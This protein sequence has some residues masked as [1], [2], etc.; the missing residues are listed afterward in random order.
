MNVFE[1][2][3]FIWI[4]DTNIDTYGE[5][6]ASFKANSSPICRLSCDGDYTLFINGRYVASNQYG[7]FEHYKIY[8]E[9]D[10]SDYILDGENHLAI[11]VHHFGK[12]SQR[13]KR[14]QTGVIF[15]ICENNEILLASNESIL[16][17]KSKSY[18]S[19]IGRE[20][21][22]QLGFSYTYDAKNEDLWQ[23]G[24]GNDFKKSLPVSK[25][26]I[27]YKRPIKK[28]IHGDTVYGNVIS[29]ENNT[30]FV[31]DLGKEITGLLSFEIEGEAD[32]EIAYG[33]SLTNGSVRKLI[34]GRRFYIDYFSKKGKN[35]FTH[36]MLRFA[37][38]YL[39]ITATSPIILHKIGLI[40]Q[41]YPTVRRAMPRLNEADA[42]IYEA[43][44]NTL[45]LCMME[46]YVDCPWREQCLYAFDSR[47]QMLCGYYAFEGG[48]TEY[49]RSNLL[50]MSKDRRSDG[51][52]SI[53]YPCGVDLTIP[54]FSLHYITS[55]KEYLI[56]S[57]DLSLYCE[58]ENKIKEILSTFTG[59]I[60]NG[61][62]PTFEGASHWNFY[63]W[64]PFSEGAL[65]QNTGKEYDCI[66][67]CLLIIALKNY[68]E[69]CNIVNK[70]FEYKNELTCLQEATKNKFFDKDRGLFLVKEE[71]SYTELVN[72]LAILADLCTQS[73]A[74]FIAGKLARGELIS[75]S[76]SFKCFKYDALLSVDSS[77]CDTV[78][79]EIRK[80][81]LKMAE[82]TSTVW[83]TDE[84]ES[85][86]D[87]AGSLCHGWSAI[88]IYYYNKL[89]NHQ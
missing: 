3:E 41:T 73:E 14:Y 35:D 55:I 17:R 10:L 51:L 77:Y 16:S 43:C 82:S 19:G 69:I 86:F 76:L 31:I 39:E 48:N 80:T 27:F 37:C 79:E 66:L 71:N 33:E 22:G 32:L 67:N 70:A 89:T 45:E 13:Y 78:L 4:D 68:K 23:I 88:P 36:Y 11:L 21:T 54:S 84:G 85:A 74:D 2:S 57:K 38:R 30:H 59:R 6:Y 44:V 7:D 81:Y 40:P 83:E 64:S 12:D 8:D 25:N 87:N 50:L 18:I 62:V 60:E 53:C 26:C 49:V 47:N 56:Y 72:S 75:C 34:G 46:H 63:D 58:V 24:Q 42:K 61:L 65:Y 1:K 20:I 52:L 28:Q 9:I 29:S 15:E 5:F